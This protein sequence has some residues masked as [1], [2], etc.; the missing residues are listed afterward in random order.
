MALICGNCQA[1][2][3][4]VI[5]TC[6][7]IVC[8]QCDDKK[9]TP[10]DKCGVIQYPKETTVT[11][12]MCNKERCVGKSLAI[13][14]TTLE[15]NNCRRHG[16]NVMKYDPNNWLTSTWLKIQELDSKESQLFKAV[17]LESKLTDKT[18]SKDNVEFLVEEHV[19][20]TLF[21]NYRW[22]NVYYNR[23]C[24]KHIVGLPYLRGYNVRKYMGST[25]HENLYQFYMTKKDDHWEVKLTRRNVEWNYEDGVSQYEHTPLPPFKIP[26]TSY[27]ED[28]DNISVFGRYVLILTEYPK[29]SYTVY[30][31]ET[32]VLWHRLILDGK[33]NYHNVAI[34][35]I[36]ERPYLLFD[37]SKINTTVV[38]ELRSDNIG[39][40]SPLPYV[41]G[42]VVNVGVYNNTSWY[43][44]HNKVACIC[45]P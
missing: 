22:N 34:I 21:P 11:C 41:T 36:D 32:Q 26:L 15:F 39:E 16:V 10:C 3:N 2:G 25:K 33:V 20:T 42:T 43:L 5:L 6:G 14:S 30:D 31:M 12:K 38:H 4:Q 27:T 1:T 7:C 13:N 24:G 28:N 35:M 44:D 45:V 18:L 19:K 37:I 17:E 8:T 40:K 29:V 9:N 23:P